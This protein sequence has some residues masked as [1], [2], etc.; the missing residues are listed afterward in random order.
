MP[1]ER[2]HRL[3]IVLTV[4]LLS[5]WKSAP[6][7]T[8][9]IPPPPPRLPPPGAVEEMIPS[10]RPMKAPQAD[11]KKGQEGGEDSSDSSSR[12]SKK[13]PLELAPPASGEVVD[14]KKPPLAPGDLCFPINLA[15]ALRLADAR[16][17]MVAAAQ[18]S[19]WAAEADLQ[20][21]KVYWVPSFN[22]GTDYIRHDGFGPDFNRGINVPQ[23]E[24][25]LGQ[26]SP[27]NP[28]HPLN[29]NINYMYS[30]VGFTYTPSTPTYFIPEGATEP[31][32]PSPEVQN[33]TD[34]IFEPLRQRQSLN[35][36]R[37]DIQHSKND[38]LHKTA[39]AYFEVHKYRGQYAGALWVVERGRNLVQTMKDLSRDLVSEVEIDRARNLLADLEQRAVSDRQMWRRASADLTRVL[40]LDPRA[41]C[42]PLEHDHMQITLIDPSRSLDDLIP[43]G[44][45]NRPELAQHQAMVQATLVAIRREKLR[46]FLPSILIN[47]FQTP[48]ELIEVGGY[49]EGSGG[50]LNLWSY[51]ND[52]S[53]QVLWQADSLGLKNMAA[54]KK[55]RSRASQALIDLFAIQDEV[56]ADVTKA[57]ADLQA[58]AARV[59]QAER[60][61]KASIANYNGNLEGL[62]QTQR[63]GDVLIQI[64][65]PQEVVFALQLL[66]RGYD[67]YFMTVAE[68]NE[69]QFELFYAL[70]YPAREISYFRP[71]NGK[72]PVDTSRPAYLPP[73]GTGPPPATR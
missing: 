25:P 55:Q 66:A 56:A 34:M 63:F 29:Q 17:L 37:W 11:E 6:G 49:G 52:V 65:R 12:P 24:G 22:F 50:N 71:P 5:S 54:V 62:K 18:V 1:M 48:Y 67:H 60:E 42:E 9:P 21:A 10:P 41:V 4:L 26:N 69:A 2:G 33:V 58:A 46:P 19:A 45:T 59:V 36:E 53:P 47:G 28:G 16:P 44:L 68:Y 15:V 32:L 27:G 51:R 57:Q 3:R 43:V 40:R 23:G 64:F 7:H 61:L 70:G 31:L 35:S 38:A 20:K 39:R 8:Q 30:G 72:V 14:L 73:V 13:S